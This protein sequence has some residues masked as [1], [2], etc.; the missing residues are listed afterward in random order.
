MP[1]SGSSR[2][3]TRLSANSMSSGFTFRLGA[4]ISASCFFRSLAAAIVALPSQKVARSPNIPESKI[5]VSESLTPWMM[6][7]KG[8]PNSSAAIWQKTVFEPWPI[9]VAPCVMIT[10]PSSRSFSMTEEPKWPPSLG[11]DG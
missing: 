8:R 2:T 10:C 4:T 3:K 1:F 11:P 9:S 5:V 7:S 6:S